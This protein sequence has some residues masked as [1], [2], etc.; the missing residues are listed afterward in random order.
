MKEGK[1]VGERFPGPVC[2]LTNPSY[3]DCGTS[4]LQCSPR[5]GPVCGSTRPVSPPR[6]VMT[7]DTLVFDEATILPFLRSVAYAKSMQAH[8][9]VRMRT[10][11]QS[12]VLNFI[13][14][15]LWWKGKPVTFEVDLGDQK[16]IEAETAKGARELQEEFVAHACKGPG[17]VTRYLKAQEDIREFCLKSVNARFLEVQELTNEV[18]AETQRGI[19][20]LSAIKAASTI[21]LKTAGLF[22]VGVPAFLIDMGYDATLEVIQE[23]DKAEG[24]ELIGVA[25][26]EG[27]KDTGQEGVEHVAEKREKILEGEAEEA[28]KRA[29]WLRKNVAK[30]EEKLAKK[31]RADLLRKYGRDSRRLAGATRAAS[32]AKWRARAFSSVKFIFFAIDIYDAIHSMR[33]D[34]HRAGGTGYSFLGG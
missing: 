31:V 9:A 28:E 2:G 5:P 22:A 12:K 15:V 4:S 3:N 29:G 11:D 34:I 26:K 24:A 13:Y 7:V 33:E 1:S 32:R 21:T 10:Y 19:F 18:I 8:V 27:A 20:K 17:S 16:T 30:E 14:T 6:A 23:W 25:I